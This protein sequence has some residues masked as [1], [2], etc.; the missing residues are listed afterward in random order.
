MS[1][2]IALILAEG[3]L[4]NVFWDSRDVLVSVLL[5]FMDSF[6]AANQNSNDHLHQKSHDN[7]LK[8][9]AEVV[10]LI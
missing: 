9:H 8:E 10:K 4:R 5:R 7:R 2:M 1:T 3:C 6:I